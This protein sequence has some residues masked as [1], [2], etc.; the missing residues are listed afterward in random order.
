MLK[1]DFIVNLFCQDLSFLQIP[2]RFS[3]TLNR[4]RAAS[5]DRERFFRKRDARLKPLQ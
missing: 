2:G 3:A 4:A 5:T 1:F